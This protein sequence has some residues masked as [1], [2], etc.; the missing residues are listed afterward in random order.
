MLVPQ[1]KEVSHEK[2]RWIIYEIINNIERDLE[3]MN[4]LGTGDR[5]LGSSRA[6]IIN[7]GFTS[8]VFGMDN[9]R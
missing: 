8:L 2:Y 3:H 1:V 6:L 4:T 7:C 5:R 9:E